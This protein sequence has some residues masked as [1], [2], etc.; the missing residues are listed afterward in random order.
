[1]II[2]LTDSFQV[3]VSNH[4]VQQMEKRQIKQTWI[5]E[6][7][8]NPIAIESDPKDADLK[9]AFGKVDCQDGLTRVLK[10]VYN[11]QVTPFKIVTIHFDR[12][13]KKRFL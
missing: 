11:D 1:M 13:A 8:I 6:V 10:V 9:W 12:K 5:R 7:L 3:F 4:A 2:Q